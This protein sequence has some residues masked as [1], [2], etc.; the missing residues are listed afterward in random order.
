[1]KGTGFI[2][3]ATINRVRIWREGLGGDK[4][5]SLANPTSLVME[6]L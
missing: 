4:N 6:H 1:M 3:I 2:V 5:S